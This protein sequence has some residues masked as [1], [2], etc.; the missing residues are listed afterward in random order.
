MADFPR[1]TDIFFSDCKISTGII[2]EKI[3]LKEF[4]AKFFRIGSNDLVLCQ[5]LKA[6]QLL[7]ARKETVEILSFNNYENL[8]FDVLTDL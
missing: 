8:Q 4:F 1:G 3:S 7:F 2:G 5:F 6:L